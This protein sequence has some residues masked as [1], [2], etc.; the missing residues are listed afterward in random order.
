M[1][2]T[3]PDPAEE[4]VLTPADDDLTTELVTST[5]AAT[6]Q[7]V[8]ILPGI[9]RE[10]QAEIR[11]AAKAFVKGLNE[12]TPQS[13]EY[14]EKVREIS[15]LGY[16]ESFSSSGATERILN[17]A[18]SSVAGA[19]KTG[20]STAIQVATTLGDLRTI[21]E[22]IDP[23]NNG[24]GVARI[25]AKL[26]FGNKINQHVQRYD[27]AKEQLDAVI[28]ALNLGKEQ[29][30]S[31]NEVLREEKVA[32]WNNMLVLRDYIYLAE[33]LVAEIKENIANAKARGDY[34][35]AEALERDVL[36]A[37]NQRYQDLITQAT[38]AAQSYMAMELVRNNNAE[39]IKGVERASHTTVVGLETAAIVSTALTNQKV[40]VDQIDAVNSATNEL[41]VRTG[42][43]LRTQTDRIHSQAASSGVDPEAL[44]KAQNDIFS[45][46]NAIDTFRVK[47]NS[48]MEQTVNVLTRQL[49]DMSPSLERVKALE[50]NDDL[51][52]SPA[53][54]YK[55]SHKAITG[56]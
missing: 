29:L 30:T 11:K 42:Q 40:V 6:A 44:R 26:P 21:V 38:M 28:D 23:N 20:N 17:N 5:S 53:L 24:K 19:K 47:A 13:P 46:L 48:Q 51:G 54:G 34:Q 49:A 9:E 18:S 45:T 27:T 36:F 4:L 15:R 14:A 32:Q 8:Q 55:S 43:A 7:A 50:T 52:G 3:P 31:D 16:E 56:K 41:I 1:K 35:T 37:A 39:L 2:L 25:I 10:E 12:L 22:G 33:N